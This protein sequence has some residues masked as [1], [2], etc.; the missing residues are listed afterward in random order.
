[1]DNIHIVKEITLTVKKK[2]LVLVFPY[3]GLISLQTRTKLKK[4]LKTSLIDVNCKQ[5]LKIR[6]DQ[7]TRFI[8]KI[9]FPKFS[10]LVSFINIS[11]GS[12][13]SYYGECVGPFN[14]ETGEHIVISPLTKKQVKPKIS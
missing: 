5:C 8:S 4:P 3:L 2:P 12:A 13:E 7:V 1:M 14:V 6:P 10:H 11:V 9:K